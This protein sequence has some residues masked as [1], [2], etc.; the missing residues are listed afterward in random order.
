MKVVLI[1]SI[2]L[3]ALLME[4]F[5]FQST[6]TTTGTFLTPSYLLLAAVKDHST[7]NYNTDYNSIIEL[8]QVISKLCRERETIFNAVTLLRD[9]DETAEGEK[10]VLPNT[11][12]YVTILK[13]L[14]LERYPPSVAEEVFDRMKKQ[15]G[16]ANVHAYNAVIATWARSRDKAGPLR[17]EEL[18]A[19]LWN[20]YKANETAQFLPNRATYM[21]VMTSWVWC[22][23]GLAAAKRTEE[24]LEE[25][26]AHRKRHQ[27][28]SPTT[29]FANVVLNAWSKSQSQGATERC[30]IILNRMVDLARNGRVELE[31]D[32]VSF[33]TAIDCLA[34]S[35]E[36]NAEWRAEALLGRMDDLATSGSPS[37]PNT[38]SFNTVLAAW[39]KS[40]QRNAAQR[41]ED[42]LLHME[43]RYESQST[44]IKPDTASYASV[45][46]A[47]SR[48]LHPQKHEKAGIILAKMQA[49][50]EKG[51]ED[52]RPD[53]M[54]YNTMIN[55][56]AK[57][58]D[59]NSG[60]LAMDILVLMKEQ[61]LRPDVF[62]YTSL[63]DVYAKQG[64]MEATEKARL[65]LVE[66]E[67]EYQET[68]S[69]EIKPNVRTYTSVINA[70]ARTRKNPEGAKAILD[71]MVDA[72]VQPDV[73]CY[74]AVINAFGWS[75]LQDKEHQ[76]YAILDQMLT[77]YKNGIVDAKPDVITCN[78]ILNACAFATGSDRVKT[79]QVAID[80]LEKFQSAAP[81]F[82]WPNH[83]SY[84]N[85]LMAISRQMPQ[86]EKRCDL[87][88]V[89]FWQCCEAGHVSILVVH[90]LRGAVTPSRLKKIL[91]PA[92]IAN[93]ESSF[94]FELREMPAK[95]KQ[96]AP[97]KSNTINQRKVTRPSA[98]RDEPAIT[99]QH[100][101]RPNAV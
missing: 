91:G 65:I 50:F 101:N 53:A 57:S 16:Q 64:T 40:R 20:L 71:R 84:A 2:I 99:K 18:L 31:P 37:E 9:A 59:T 56:W 51:N 47:W 67:Q 86:S 39:S 34:R 3:V 27:Y 83:I 10:K 70:I 43:R 60:K 36:H 92:L 24:L 45:M 42:I 48:S 17:A 100:I 32:T 13:A 94:R 52:A 62:T 41:A 5:A 93:S 35:G 28:L 21:G 12:T 30:E 1:S 4:S 77:S 19:E 73:V 54:V 63:I 7:S 85:M 98:K 76:A 61:G 6:L 15:C 89:T 75:D 79:M 26:E 78:S 44:N 8:N 29:A 95:W 14:V 81:E 23:E 25:M 80:T 69:R 49:A 38:M 68:G 74:N 97:R 58:N 72:N 11:E 55:V 87:A 88:E 90:S 33:N 96:F 46:H 22:G 82:G 66:M